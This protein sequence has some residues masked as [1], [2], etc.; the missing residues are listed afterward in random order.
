MSKLRLFFRTFDLAL[1]ILVALILGGIGAF[2]IYVA[3]HLWEGV[4]WMAVIGGVFVLVALLM[5]IYR[6]T[7]LR[8]LN[9]F[10]FTTWT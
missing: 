3:W 1:G 4:I 5:L 7:F 9:F 8:F 6:V 2:L 10:T